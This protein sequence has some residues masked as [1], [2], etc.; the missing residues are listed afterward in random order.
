MKAGTTAVQ[1]HQDDRSERSDKSADGIEGLPQSKAGAPQLDRREIGDEGVAGSVAHAFPDPVDEP[2]RHHP[3]DRGGEREDRLGERRQSVAEGRQ[4]LAMAEPVGKRTGK[5]LRDVCG[6][7]GD[8][9]DEAD[10][11]C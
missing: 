10:R 2:R 9:F 6:R 3:S 11:Q 1:C 5:D 8:A 4:Q 7:L